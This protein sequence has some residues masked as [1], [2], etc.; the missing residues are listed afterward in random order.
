MET[1][2]NAFNAICRWCGS[3]RIALP[4]GVMICDHCDYGISNE[5]VR[6]TIPTRGE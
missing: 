2:R 1:L 6:S 3:A 4:S 5:G